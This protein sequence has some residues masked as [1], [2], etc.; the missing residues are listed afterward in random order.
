[1]ARVDNTTTRS[2]VHTI[3]A[4]RLTPPDGQ[5]WA[6]VVSLD[7]QLCSFLLKVAYVSVWWL[8]FHWQSFV[9]FL[10]FSLSWQIKYIFILFVFYFSILVFILLISFFCFYSLYR[11]F[12]F[13]NSIIQLHFLICFIFNFSPHSFNFLFHFYSF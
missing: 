9:F 11:F 4:T 7:A 3:Q 10:F 5:I 12:L 8:D 13:C 6:F 2:G 1:L